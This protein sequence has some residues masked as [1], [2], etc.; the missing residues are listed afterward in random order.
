MGAVSER[1]VCVVCVYQCVVCA[2]CEQINPVGVC[3]GGVWV[4]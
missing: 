4:P 2:V 1:E 3:M